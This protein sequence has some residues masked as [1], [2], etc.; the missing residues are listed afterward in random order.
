MPVEDFGATFQM[1]FTTIIKKTI[2]GI[3]FTSG[4]VPDICRIFVK[5]SFIKGVMMTGE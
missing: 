4:A 5:A 1:V 3:T 2:K